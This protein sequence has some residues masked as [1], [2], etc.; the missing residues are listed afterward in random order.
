MFVALGLFIF[1]TSTALYNDIERRRSWAQARTDRFG[2][3]P[4]AQ[5]T[6]PASDTITLTGTLLPEVCGKYSQ[7]EQLAEMADTGDAYPFVMRDGVVGFYTIESLTDKHTNL[8]EGGFARTIDFQLELM[9]VADETT[10]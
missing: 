6:G 10:A 2:A 9:R 3:L 1:D 5:F 7:I 8:I 4:A